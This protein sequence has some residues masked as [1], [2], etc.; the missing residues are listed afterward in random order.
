MQ[1][2]ECLCSGSSE[3]RNLEKLF[4]RHIQTVA[5]HNILR[6]KR[7]DNWIL[8]WRDHNMEELIHERDS[9]SQEL[10]RNNSEQ[11]RNKLIEASSKAGEVANL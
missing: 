2:L 11:L 1:E 7:K 4:T 6:G 5:R 3:N 10:M 9:I 8:F